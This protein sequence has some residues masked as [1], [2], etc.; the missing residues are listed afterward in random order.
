MS[1]TVLAIAV[2][3]QFIL[4]AIWYGPLFGKMWMKIVGAEDCTPEKMK[5]MQKKMIPYYVIQILITL[6]M[7]V[8][9][10]AAISL[11]AGVSPYVTALWVLAGF[12]IPTQ[13]SGVIWSGTKMENHSKQIS[14]MVVGQIIFTAV[15]VC[16][17][18][19]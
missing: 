11:N 6:V 18:T 8:V 4:G 3:V 12:I 19:F 17:L 9:L 14:I 15:A 7:T 16:I 13:I 10:W 2:I 1:Y 5:E